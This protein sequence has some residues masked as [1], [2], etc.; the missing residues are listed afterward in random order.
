MELSDGSCQGTVQVVLERGNLPNYE[1]MVKLN[2]GAAVL[3]TGQVVLTPRC[4]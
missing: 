2:V 1:E 4:V 3:V